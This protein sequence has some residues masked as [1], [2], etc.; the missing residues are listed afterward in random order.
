[1]YSSINVSGKGTVLN[2]NPGTYIILGGGFTVSATAS[3]NGSGVNVFNA[4]SLYDYTTG[5]T[6][7]GGNYGG[8]SI[9]KNGSV[10]LTAPTSG[11]YAGILLFQPGDNTRALAFAAKAVGSLTGVIYAPKALVSISGN[12]ALSSA[13]FVVSELALSG[14]GSSSE[15]VDGANGSSNT[16]GQL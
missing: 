12:A 3:V 5:T 7:S 16:A 9:G 2:L 11:A 8:I 14:G 1:V 6:Q 13:T 4:S 10:T 15:M